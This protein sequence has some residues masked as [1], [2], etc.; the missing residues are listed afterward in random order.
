MHTVNALFDRTINIAHD[1]TC[2]DNSAFS[3]YVTSRLAAVPVLGAEVMAIAKETLITAPSKMISLVAGLGA[4]VIS[5]ISGSEA[6]KKFA[7]KQSDLTDFLRTVGKIVVSV[8]GIGLTSTIGIISPD[9]N[10]AL[11]CKLGLAINQKEELDSLQKEWEVINGQIRH[12]AIEQAETIAER[13][14]KEEVKEE[15]KKIQK[16]IKNDFAQ[17][18]ENVAE[19]LEHAEEDVT[20]TF[21]H[22][23][24]D[25]KEAIN[26]AHDR[27]REIIARDA[28]VEPLSNVIAEET[29]SAEDDSD[30]D[31][32]EEDVAQTEDEEVES[33]SCPAALYK[34]STQVGSLGK[35]TAHQ[36]ASKSIW[37]GKMIVSGTTL[38]ANTIVSGTKLTANTVVSGTKWTA[39]TVVSGTKWTA[40]QVASTGAWAVNNTV[41]RL[42]AAKKTD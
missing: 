13:I 37:T 27:T 24:E 38:T 39:N 33:F 1:L 14:A 26:Y 28:T 4:R 31:I 11:H 20:A 42:F 6:M 41:G 15:A 34:V 22:V 16:D 18:E 29:I 36:A 7:E 2:P 17:A 30:S 12:L 21:Q 40:N 10:F 8:I 19:V 5:V 3:R 32:E 23:K 25:V 35:W 9:A